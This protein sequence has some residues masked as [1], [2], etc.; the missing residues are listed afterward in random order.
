MKKSKILI[1][2]FGALVANLLNA[3]VQ[4]VELI[5]D[6]VERN[7]FL[8]IA[9][10]NVTVYSQDYFLTADR[11]TYDEKNEII[12]LF[13]NVNAMRGDNET[14]RAEY[15]K[16]DLKNNTQEGKAT[17]MM[18]KDAELWM[19]N[20]ESC[21]DSEYYRVKGSVISSCN[22]ND[23]DWKIKFSSGKLNK[24]SKFLHLF[25]PR[26]YI[27]DV[28][29]FYLPY[30]GVPTDTTRRTGLL[31]PEGGYIGDE[32]VY[33]KQPI[34]FAPYDSWDLQL[35]PQVR[36]RRG[37]GVY[38]TFRFADSPYSR[39]EIRGGVFDNFTRAQERLEYKNE[40]HYGYEI[41]YDRSKLVGYLIDGD[42]KENLWIDFTKLNDLEYYD[43]K[44]KGGVD[45]DDN[46]LVTSKLNYYLTTDD[47]YFGLYGRYYI[48]T[49]KLNQDSIFQN[50][51]TVQELP[52]VQY[53]KFIDDIFV[54][55]LLYSV[56]LKARNFTRQEGVTARQYELDIPLSYSDRFLGDYLGL[57][58]SER[59]Y[60]TH[61][62]WSDKYYYAN[63]ELEAD[64][65][66]FY[67]NQYTEFSAFTDLAKAYESFYHT[68]TWR[69][70]LRIPGWQK[71]EIDKRILKSHQYEYDEKNGNLRKSRLARLQDSLYW[72]DNFLG[73]LADEYTH[74]NIA[75]G[76]TQYFYD[77]NGRKFIR[78]SAKQSYDFDDE[79]LG[80]FD[81]RF[82][83]YFANGLN[84]GNR[85]TYSHKYDSFSKVQTYANY[86]NS[87]FS[88]SISHAYTYDQFGD[89]NEKRYKKDNYTIANL[90]A[91]LPGNNKIFG[92]W[93]YDLARSYSKMWRLGITHTRKCWNYSFVY[94]ED[95]EPKNTSNADY[96]KA[97]KEHGFYFFVNFYP[98][99]GVGY[100]FSV[101]T[102]Y[103]EAQ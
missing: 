101:D 73:E 5:A 90:S 44:S 23:P 1:L 12:E 83:I 46:A 57:S 72:E 56:D 33:Y 4:N 24:E 49:S 99:G 25:N 94:Q 70:D 63:G 103:G 80:N 28:P 78:H 74:E 95:I 26:F 38:G 8:T 27:G 50:R 48:D 9:R 66:T 3:K 19:Q 34:Y 43:L 93:E 55:N 37:F 16:I 35:D 31:P 54:P 86:S 62:D 88:A 92:R 36:S 40:K 10:G 85:F 45:E 84:L 39:G 97:K 60:M 41:E 32:G 15:I 11:A 52:T 30:F 47:H 71:G 81:H 58:V 22:V 65:S 102:E 51:D 68:M 91:N 53:H 20:D 2:T 42:F 17:F 18:D 61:I 76:M 89:E 29:V 98:F 69:A 14:T 6:N 75:L 59:V 100:D 87:D 82:D 77:E 7:G 13:G 79:E 64:K 21:S 96:T 67:A